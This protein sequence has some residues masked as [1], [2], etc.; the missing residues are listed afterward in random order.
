MAYGT[1][2]NKT[3]HPSSTLATLIHRRW[4]WYALLL[5]IFAASRIMYYLLGVR[6]DA[7]GLTW[8]F[9][10]LD[11]ELLRHNLLQSLFYL[12]IQPPGYNLYLGIVLKLFPHAEVTAFHAIHL[13][14]GATITC[15]MF[16]VMRN[17]GIRAVIAFAAAALF[18]TSPG[19]VLFENFILYEYMQVFTLMVCAVSL[20][21]FFQNHNTAGAIIFLAGQFWLVMLKSHYHVVYF[22]VVFI[23]LLCFAKRKRRLIAGV[24]SV[25]CAMVLAFYLKNQVLFGHFAGCTWMGMNMATITTHHLTP[26]E[27]GT[28]VA[29]GRIS[30]IPDIDAVVPLAAYRPYITM[31]ARRSI[32]VLDEEL[33]STGA[34][35][36]NHPGFLEVG[37]LYTKDGRYILRHYPRAYIRSVAIAWFTYF[38][39]PTDFAFFDLNAPHIRGIERFFDMVF[40]GQFRQIT[41]RKKLRQLNSPVI[42]LYTGVF[43][44]L[45]LPALFIYGL[46]FLYRGVRR[47]TLD[48]GRA[49]VIGYMLFIIAYCT[50]IANFLS[51][52]ENN[53]YRFPLD[54]F[55]VVLAA[56]ALDTAWRKIRSRSAA[57]INGETAG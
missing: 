1:A 17:L 5:L 45:G 13:V 42:V 7:R 22:T 10:F 19:V 26:Q 30:P 31:P 34:I 3:D 38:L 2:V 51:S 43:L 14:F 27:R 49:I 33:K 47:G 21:W 50:G 20:F 4:A 35:N 52:V 8:F 39:P 15:M 11:P 53:R 41:D 28:F 44:L 23:L 24:G 55:F 54:G 57:G 36:F 25:F 37:K 32:P 18:M 9:Q 40:F 16:Y 12:H 48:A 56:L 46:V 6:F 29:Q